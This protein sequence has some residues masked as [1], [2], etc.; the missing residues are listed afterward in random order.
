MWVKIDDGF[1]THP[2]LLAA[3]PLA[4]LLQIRAICFASQNKTDGFIPHSAV[5]LLQSGFENLG[6]DTGSVG[7][8]A[9]VG[10][11]ANDIEWAPYMVEYGLWETRDG[12]YYIHDYLKWNLSK[13]E[14]EVFVKKKSIAGKK[15]MKSRWNKRKPVITHVISPDI[16]NSYHPTSTSISSSLNSSS[17]NSSESEFEQ[18]WQA[19]PR[20]VGGKK[21]ALKAW[22][23]ARDKPPLA[24]LLAV[25]ENAKQAEQ[26]KRDGGQYIPYPATW[27]NRGM[28]ADDV[29]PLESAFKR[30]LNSFLE[31][32]KEEE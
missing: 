19:Y 32:H 17:L 15:G 18:F 2:K 8:Y 11:Q 25:L 13:K 28:W 6:I 23:K 10:C 20:K 1:A 7:E 3:G 5:L 9:T 27:L 14:Q 24:D 12:G 31:R 22:E 4:A 29:R 16:T 21:S 26:W 30:G